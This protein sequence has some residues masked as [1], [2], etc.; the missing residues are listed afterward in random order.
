MKMVHYEFFSSR[1][2]FLESVTMLSAKLCEGVI[3]E[4]II[5]IIF[6]LM[7]RGNRSEP[8]L[9]VYKAGCSILI[10]LARYQ[11]TKVALWENVS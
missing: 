11:P 4:G 3:A 7:A 5:P 10:N 1:D 8:S 6:S 2:Y 9:E